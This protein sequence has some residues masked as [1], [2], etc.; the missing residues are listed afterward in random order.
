MATLHLLLIASAVVCGL[1]CQ[2][3]AV[4]VAK[5]FNS[6]L[7]APNLNVKYAVIEDMLGDIHDKTPE[8]IL[9]YGEDEQ[10]IYQTMLKNRDFIRKEDREYLERV[11]KH[12]R[13]AASPWGQILLHPERIPNPASFFQWDMKK[14]LFEILKNEYLRNHLVEHFHLKLKSLGKTGYDYFS[15]RNSIKAYR[16]V[17]LNTSPTDEETCIEQMRATWGYPID[18]FL[19][20]IEEIVVYIL[21]VAEEAYGDTLCETDPNTLGKFLTDIFCLLAGYDIG[22]RECDT[23]K[24]RYGYFCP[25]VEP[26]VEIFLEGIA[27]YTVEPYD[28][29]TLIPWLASTF[30]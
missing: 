16:S 14:F 6:Y 7:N 8:E 1:V 22:S 23:L 25:L 15:E 27:N 5:F 9:Q 3:E 28:Q 13:A 30:L 12:S 11:L 21:Q 2:S 18:L 26:L 20:L 17:M 24:R 4:S 29:P 10:D 19:N